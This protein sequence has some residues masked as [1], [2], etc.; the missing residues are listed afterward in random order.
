M[1]P[2]AAHVTAWDY[3]TPAE[4][5]ARLARARR[6]QKAQRAGIEALA[7]E[8][9]ARADARRRRQETERAEL[10]D[11][12]GLDRYAQL[13]AGPAAYRDEVERLSAQRRRARAKVDPGDR[14]RAAAIERARAEKR[15]RRRVEGWS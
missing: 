15:D 13:A 9:E 4:E 8:A 10:A 7:I 11:R 1:R 2:Q 14:S 6:S 5:R 12:W 3:P